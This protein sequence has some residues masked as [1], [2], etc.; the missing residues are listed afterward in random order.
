MD[1]GKQFFCMS[2]NLVVDSVAA[3]SWVMA[4]EVSCQY[5]FRRFYGVP[6]SVLD[7]GSN[8]IQRG[9]HCDLLRELV[10]S[11]RRNVYGEDEYLDLV[12]PYLHHRYIRAVA[13]YLPVG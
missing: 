3:P 12:C 7:G 11:D 5:D 1:E 8:L 13:V 4:V 6:S 9:L 10:V 2:H